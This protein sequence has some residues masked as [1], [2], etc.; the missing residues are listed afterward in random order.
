M[1]TRVIES[2]QERR[3][4][5]LKREIGN[6]FQRGTCLLLDAEWLR[7]NDVTL[8]ENDKLSQWIASCCRTNIAM[9][10]L[11]RPMSTKRPRRAS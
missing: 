9:N 10:A 7:E 6:G 2:P 1:S 5:R 3:W 8:T 4:I 11:L